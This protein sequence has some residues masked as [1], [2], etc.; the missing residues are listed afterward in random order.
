MFT[1]LLILVMVISASALV[2]DVLNN[3]SF[4]AFFY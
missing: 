3:I 2:S 4:H 1:Y